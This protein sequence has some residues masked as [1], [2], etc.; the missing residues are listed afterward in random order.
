MNKDIRPSQHVLH[1]FETNRIGRPHDEVEFK[2][3]CYV[4]IVNTKTKGPNT[5]YY[6]T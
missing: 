2:K 6:G 3:S 1:V 4:D 5:L